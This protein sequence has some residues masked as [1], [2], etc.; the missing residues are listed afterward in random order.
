MFTS[1][2]LGFIKLLVIG[3]LVYYTFFYLTEGYSEEYNIKI[4]ALEQKVDSLHSLNDG[5]TFKIDTLNQ[6]IGVLDQEIDL[7]DNRINNLKYEVK[8]K[9]DAVDKFNVSEL[10]QFFTDR[11]RQH[12]DSIKKTYST[13]SN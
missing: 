4:K 10:E 5:L 1:K 6:Q 11:Y 8:N 7:K 12:L 3:L 2:V 13:S 9:V